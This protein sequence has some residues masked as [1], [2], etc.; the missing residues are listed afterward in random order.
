M[1]SWFPF[2]TQSTEV[3][4][5]F[6]ENDIR[7]YLPVVTNNITADKVYARIVESSTEVAYEFFFYWKEQKGSY[8]VSEHEHDWEF[9]VVYTYPNGTISQ[10][11]YDMWHYYIGRTT[12]PDCYNDTNV[13]VYINEDFHYFKPDRGIR[14]GNVTWQINNQTIYELTEA[15]LQ[16]AK[17]QV[18]FD[19]EL[20]EDPFAWKEKGW[21]GRYTAFDSWWKAFWVVLDKEYDWIDLSDDS[22]LMTRWL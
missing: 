20:Y 4:Y 11:S 17:E 18:G 6:K 1:I 21:L 14:S 10:V 3:T 13:L 8:K 19:T 16:T 5:S 2:F 22:R 15:V 9:I 7:V 12:D